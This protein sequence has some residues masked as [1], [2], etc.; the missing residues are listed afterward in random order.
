MTMRAA[1]VPIGLQPLSFRRKITR[2]MCQTNGGALK[3]FHTD[4]G[5]A[6]KLGYPDLVAAG[7]MFIC[8]LSELMTQCF[9][10]RWLTSGKLDV[11]FLRPVIAGDTITARATVTNKESVRSQIRLTLD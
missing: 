10:E 7:P 11:K 4:L 6:Q 9:G 2:K 1:D 8:F 5:E 3:N